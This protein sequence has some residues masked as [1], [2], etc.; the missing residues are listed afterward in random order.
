[1]LV[2]GFAWVSSVVFI[3]VHFVASLK[4]IESIFRLA[5]THKM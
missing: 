1:M 5:T 3:A 4:F 2:Y